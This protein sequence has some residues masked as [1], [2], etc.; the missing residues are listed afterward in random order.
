[1]VFLED[2]LS[3]SQFLLVGH[4]SVNNSRVSRDVSIM[5]SLELN[6]FEEFPMCCCILCLMMQTDVWPL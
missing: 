4:I 2:T 5:T 3:L 6:T 1:M